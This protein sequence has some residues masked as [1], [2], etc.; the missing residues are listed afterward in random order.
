MSIVTYQAPI[1]DE[2]K[3]EIERLVD[4]ADWCQW[5]DGWAECQEDSG[6]YFSVYTM[7]QSMV[8]FTLIWEEGEKFYL[9]FVFVTPDYQ[10]QGICK[11]LIEH[12]KEL[13]LLKGKNG[14]ALQATSWELVAMYEKM[15]FVCT[16]GKCMICELS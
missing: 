7:N 14:L 10:S 16:N 2:I 13:V 9:S 4:D 8:A 5:N 3:E 11:K 15:G 12:A 1:S 6:C